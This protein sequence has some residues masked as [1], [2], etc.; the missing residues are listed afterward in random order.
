VLAGPARGHEAFQVG[1][2]PPG[3]CSLGVGLDDLHLHE[4]GERRPGQGVDVRGRRGIDVAGLL[5]GEARRVRRLCD[6][7]SLPDPAFTPGQSGPHQRVPVLKVER[8]AHQVVGGDETDAHHQA[9]LG[10]GELGHLRSAVTTELLAP[11]RARQRRAV[12]MRDRLGVVQGGPVGRQDQL[13][14]LVLAQV[15]LGPG[16]H[17]ARRLGVQVGDPRDVE[18]VFDSTSLHRQCRDRFPLSTKRFLLVPNASDE[19]MGRS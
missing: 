4:S 14:P 11:L 2:P 7:S 18:H 17:R 15:L 3:L 19:D 13:A 6:L 9:Q 5:Q 16:D 1:R 12:S 10:T 8:V